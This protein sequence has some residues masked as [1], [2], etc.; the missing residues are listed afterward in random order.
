MMIKKFRNKLV[1][2]DRNFFKKSIKNF[3]STLNRS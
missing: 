3:L 1:N 2:N